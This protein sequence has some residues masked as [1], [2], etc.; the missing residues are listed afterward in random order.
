[1]RL[2]APPSASSP[3]W[4]SSPYLLWR[5]CS[6]SRSM[7][8]ASWRISLLLKRSPPSM[9]YSDGSMSAPL[10]IARS[11]ADM[12]PT[13][14]FI[15]GG[16]LFNSREIRQLAGDMDR[17][18]EHVRQSKYGDELQAGLDAL[19]GADSLMDFERATDAA[20]L[21]Y[22]KMLSNRYPLSVCPVLAYVIAKERE[23]TN[24]RAIARGREAGLSESEIESELVML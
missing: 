8:P 14:N 16:D 3:A 10:R 13:E 2:S 7:S 17:L 21:E 15:A 18:V 9:K 6:T 11:G 19:G 12:E 5:T 4:S 23:M 20:L 24:I 1:M 22:A